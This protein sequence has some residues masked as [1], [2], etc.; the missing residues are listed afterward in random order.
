MTLTRRS[1]LQGLGALMVATA[2]ALPVGFGEDPIDLAE[3]HKKLL[4]YVFKENAVHELVYGH[5]LSVC[6]GTKGTEC[7]LAPDYL[8]TYVR[9]R[10]PSEYRIEWSV[11]DDPENWEVS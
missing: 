5:S 1:L 6:D 4:M 2:T 10:T 7:P 3:A 8:L 11:L 9:D